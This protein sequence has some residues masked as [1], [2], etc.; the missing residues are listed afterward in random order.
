MQGHK[1][2]IRA[3]VA[4]NLVTDLLLGNDWISENNVIIDTPQREIIITD[5][6]RRIIATAKF[7]EPSALRLPVLLAEEITLPPY[8]E[9]C[10]NVKI[11]RSKNKITEGLF[12][13]TD[14]FQSKQIL[15][16]HTILK[17]EIPLEL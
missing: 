9:Q 4:T 2:I 5:Q 10:I 1:T 17:I 16:T 6:Y 15:L 14:N 7:I 13:P 3:D 11:E 12:E 8:S